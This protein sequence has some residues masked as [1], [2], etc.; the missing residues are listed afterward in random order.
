MRGPSSKTAAKMSEPG[1]GL[2]DAFPDVEAA[3]P[4]PPVSRAREENIKRPARRRARAGAA[5]RRGRAAR[6]RARRAP[7]RSPARIARRRSRSMCPGRS[8]HVDTA[9][10]TVS[11]RLSGVQVVEHEAGAVAGA[12][13]V[14]DHGVGE[15]AGRAHDRQRPV[16]QAVHLVQAA[17]L[18]ARRHQE[19]VAAG[20]DAVRPR[21]VEADPGGEAVAVLPRD[22]AKNRS[23][24]GSPVP[25][26]TNWSVP[27]EDAV[28]ARA[29]A[30]R[31]PSARASRPTNPKS[32]TSARDGKRR[33]RA[34][35][36]PCRRPSRAGRRRRSG[37]RGGGR[38]PGSTPRRRCRSG[39]R[40]GR[41]P[42]PA[43][44]P[45]SPKPYAGVWIS[46]A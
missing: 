11:A 30:R 39:C 29:R 34:A 40:A 2:G 41:A 33:P 22:P 43:R 25:R 24:S 16:A 23:A 45:S 31:S 8:Y 6:T 12:L 15:A 3:K 36:R 38:S 1:N 18:E 21:V 37:P 14:V 46:R 5:W 17:R 20:L 7:T 32:G 13:V 28:R 9:Q 26:R 19:E 4:P 42:R 44:T 27:A 10:P 35:G